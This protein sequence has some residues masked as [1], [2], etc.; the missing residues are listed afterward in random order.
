MSPSFNLVDEPWLPCL[1]AEAPRPREL[2]IREALARAPDIRRLVDPSPLVTVALHR[3]LLAILH[4]V[5]GPE[6]EE[7]WVALWE[8]GHFEQSRL[9]AYL[10][11]SR[12]RPQ[13]DLFDPER[14][15][16]QT[17]NLPDMGKSIVELGHE[18]S[19]GA[20][21]LLFDHS[22]DDDP[23]SLSPAFAA[24]LLVAHQAFAR[25]GTV[26]PVAPATK[27]AKTAPLYRGAVLLVMGENLFQTLCLNL[28]RLN[29]SEGSPWEFDSR[30]DRPTWERPEPPGVVEREPAGYLDYLTWQ[31]RRVL[32]FPDNSA[33]MTI[34]RRCVTG[35][36]EQLPSPD[37]VRRYEQMV[38]YRVRRKAKAG[39]EPWAP[40]GF[41]PE[42]ALWRDSLALFSRSA[43]EALRPALL[44]QL[45][46]RLW[47]FGVE[48]EFSVSVGGLRYDPTKTAEVTLWRHE[49]LPLPFAYLRDD[50]LVSALGAGIKAAEE[51][52]RRLREAVWRLAQQVLAP[53]GNADSARVS[54]LADALAPV[55]AY[56]PALDVPFRRFMRELAAGYR[57][58]LGREAMQRWAGVIHTGA[59]E[60]FEQTA[61]AMETSGR[62]YRAAAEARSRFYGRLAGALAPIRPEE[63][64]A[65]EGSV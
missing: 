65:Q 55:R 59:A 58:D 15:F 45:T 42:K 12:P 61:R 63:Q 3:L 33:G 9:D 4:R 53:E 6:S 2:S 36:G 23:P 32:L 28:V 37:L 38:A 50:D 29:G 35:V 17:P 64:V 10:S 52:G 40:I 49:E 18:F 21:K 54:A 13:F 8:R 11:Q 56:W 41:Q 48:T 20:S 39:E 31:P 60:A 14:P 62:G 16:Y 26:T 27:Y 7:E 30:R 34:V 57:T 5:F 22:I 1:L 44:N 47:Y 51:A 24:R 25:G 19:V 43:D 46:A